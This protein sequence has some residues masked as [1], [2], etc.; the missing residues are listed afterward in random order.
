[1][2]DIK[3]IFDIKAASSPDKLINDQIL[4][5]KSSLFTFL[6]EEQCEEVEFNFKQFV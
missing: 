2:V 1:M 4:G 6:R 3:K 5:I